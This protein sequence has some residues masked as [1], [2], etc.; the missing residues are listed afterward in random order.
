[1]RGVVAV[2]T[3]RIGSQRCRRAGA[4]AACSTVPARKPA[5]FPTCVVFADASLRNALDEANNLFRF[6]NGSGAVMS[7]GASSA[8][9][10]KIESGTPADVFIAADL[11]SMDLRRRAQADPCRRRARSFW[12]T[13]SCSSP[14]PTVPSR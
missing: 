4:S 13:S 5:Q 9:A 1:M 10:K 7:Y 8:L 3:S 6:E 11:E 2:A 14:A 12:A